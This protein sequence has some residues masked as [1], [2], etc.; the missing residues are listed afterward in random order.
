MKLSERS[1]KR[2]QEIITGDAKL[3]AYRS[4]PQL[5]EFFNEH[6]SNHVYKA[7]FPSRWVFAE[8]CIREANDTPKLKN[9]ILAAL[10]PR[11]YMGKTYYDSESLTHK[12]VSIENA[13]KHLND[14]FQF[15][16]YEIYPYKNGYN[17]RETNGSE[18]IFEH[19]LDDSKVSYAFISEQ[20]EKC[21]NKIA[22]KDFDGAITNARSL[23]EAVLIHIEEHF[24]NN[25]PKY[26]GDLPKL[27]KRV[28]KH[29][30][31]APDNQEIDDNLKQ[32]LRGFINIINGLSGLSNRMGDRH[33]REY[34]PA[35]HHATLLVNSAMT[36]CNFIF[37][38]YIYQQNLKKDGK[39]L[40]VAKA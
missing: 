4:G 1:I 10:D 29:L 35:K 3:S 21:R 9:I 25:A 8:A 31:L 22:D 14:F 18:V 33:V 38:T 39:T 5:V 11:D 27:Y 19:Q 24:D 6:G 30:N 34:K 12:P 2:L 28:Q 26:D 23:I 7:G 40:G 17:I 13:V 15:D 20:I 36:L 37:D 32:T 16:G